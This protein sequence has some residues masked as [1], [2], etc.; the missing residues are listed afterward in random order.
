MAIPLNIQAE[1]EFIA[2]VDNVELYWVVLKNDG[3]IIDE[4]CL[5]VE[6]DEE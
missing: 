3:G 6:H 4:R 2:E 1:L 5:L